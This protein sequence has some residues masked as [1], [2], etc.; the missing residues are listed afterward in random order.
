LAGMVA[1]R[2][3]THRWTPD[4]G[5]DPATRAQQRAGR[6]ARAL[7]RSWAWRVSRP[8]RNRTRRRAGLPPEPAD[9]PPLTEP[10]AAEEVLWGVIRSRSWSLLAGPRLFLRLLQARR[11]QAP[12]RRRKGS[13][14][15]RPFP[16]ANGRHEGS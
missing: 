10:G 6:R 5:A 12:W 9:P 7:W 8:L 2:A 16:T 13:D 15:I 14:T 3:G 11:A 1:R 4:I